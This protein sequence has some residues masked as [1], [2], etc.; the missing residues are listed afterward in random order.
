MGHREE[1]NQ[2]EVKNSWRGCLGY[3]GDSDYI[4]GVAL[5]DFKAVE[6]EPS[7]GLLVLG[8][9]CQTPSV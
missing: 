2:D 9:L 4:E 3:G 6:G 8:R 7:R 1:K 5:G